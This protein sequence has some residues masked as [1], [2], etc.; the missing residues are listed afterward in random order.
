MGNVIKEI[1]CRR[2]G[3]TEMRSSQ[4]KTC[5]ACAIIL[6]REREQNR[7]RDREFERSVSERKKK[8][9]QGH[10]PIIDINQAAKDHGMS[11]GQYTALMRA[12]L[13]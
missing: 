3:K 7:W 8:A 1:T 12:G 4:A 6:K 9:K 13:I 10:Q 5:A 11:Y 2:C